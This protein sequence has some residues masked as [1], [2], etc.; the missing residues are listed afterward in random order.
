MLI[1]TVRRS[2]RGPMLRAGSPVQTEAISPYLTSFAIGRVLL[3]L[4]RD[5]RDDRAE[6]SCAIVDEFSSPATTVGG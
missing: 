2:G 4:E 1:P 6:S 3:V 5:D